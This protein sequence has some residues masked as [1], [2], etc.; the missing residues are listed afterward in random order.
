MTAGP[1]HHGDYES[2]NSKLIKYYFPPIGLILIKHSV[3]NCDI[4]SVVSR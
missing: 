1:H 2:H 3:D 4:I